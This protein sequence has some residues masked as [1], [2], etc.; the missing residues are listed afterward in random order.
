MLN[1]TP[2]CALDDGNIYN[3]SKLKKNMLPEV[4]GSNI[5]L[6]TNIIMKFRIKIQVA[7][8]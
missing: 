5:F 6:H 3:V 4:K 1:I 8:M 7:Y 2:V